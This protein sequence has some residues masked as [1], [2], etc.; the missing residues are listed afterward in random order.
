MD[1]IYRLGDPAFKAQTIEEL[2][3]EVLKYFTKDG[4]SAEVTIDKDTVRVLLNENDIKQAQRDLANVRVL[5]DQGKFKEATTILNKLL[6]NH[7]YNSEAYRLLAQI[8]QVNGEYETAI[9]HLIDAL[10]CN[11]TNIGALIVMGNIFYKDMKD[12]KAALS[13]Y[14]KALQLQPENSMAINNLASI[15]AEDGDLEKATQMFKAAIETDATNENSYYGLAVIYYKDGKFEKAFE[16]ARKGCVIG[17][18]RPENPGMSKRLSDIMLATAQAITEKYNYKDVYLGIKDILEEQA[19]AEIREEADEKL[20]VYAQLQY[21]PARGRR[22]HLLRYNPKRPFIPHLMVHELMHLDMTLEANSKGLGGQVVYSSNENEGKFRARYA[23]WA[24]KLTDKFGYTKAQEVVGQILSGLMVQVMNCPLDLFV[25]KRMFDK[26]KVMRPLQ[27]LS[28]IGQEHENIRLIEGSTKSAF[29]PQPLL[30]A[31]KIMNIVSSINLERLYG[32]SLTSHYKPT[33]AELDTALELYNEYEAYADKENPYTP[34]EEYDLIK[35]FAETLDLEDYISFS[36]EKDFYWQNKE[37][38]DDMEDYRDAVIG[39]RVDSI[40][41]DTGNSIDG[42][43]DAQK[44]RQDNF[45][46]QNKDGQ[47]DAK[48]MMMAMYMVG[49]LE[50]FEGQPKSFI[51]KVAFEIAQIGMTGISPEVKDYVVK[52]LGDKVMTGYQLLGYYYVSWKLFN[53]ELH[54]SLNSPSTPLG[55]PPRKFT[56]LKRRAI[57]NWTLTK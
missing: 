38:Q 13:Y 1:I 31:S 30:R 35:F 45:Y 9:D 20:Q 49:A 52:S 26:Y 27:L 25:E 18:S 4:F 5:C 46:K 32:I 22:W 51:Q 34:G 44:E 37:K 29:I 55:K 56:T 33:K 16:W 17:V 3:D 15:Y 36:P 2:Y 14:E 6:K 7:P 28:L 50:T 8:E 11:P 54:K 23:Q 48:T 10:R 47:D 57:T 12:R 41:G 19:H 39:D 53:P 43:S 42:L 21:G 24:K 40:D